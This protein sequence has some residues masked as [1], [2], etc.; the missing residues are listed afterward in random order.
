M[1]DLINLMSAKAALSDRLNGALVM[2]S[3]G[4]LKVF[5]ECDLET[6]RGYAVEVVSTVKVKNRHIDEVT[7]ESRKAVVMRPGDE[8][9]D[10]DIAKEVAAGMFQ[11]VSN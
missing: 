10:I 6:F 7:D 5:G 9:Y 4:K 3:D 1:T 11:E 8:G 2:V